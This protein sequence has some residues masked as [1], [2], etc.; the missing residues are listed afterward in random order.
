[1]TWCPARSQ[2]CLTT[3]PHLRRRP[4]PPPTPRSPPPRSPCTPSWRPAPPRPRSPAPRA[5]RSPGPHSGQTALAEPRKPPA[6]GPCA[7]GSG[8]RGGRPPASTCEAA[9]LQGRESPDPAGSAACDRARRCRCPVGLPGESGSRARRHLRRGRTVHRRAGRC[10]VPVLP[11][12]RRPAGLSRPP[13]SG[14]PA[15]QARPVRRPA[16]REE[17]HPEGRRPPVRLPPREGQGGGLQAL[18]PRAGSLAAAEERRSHRSAG[19]VGETSG[20]QDGPGPRG[21]SFTGSPRPPV[22]ASFPQRVAGSRGRPA[23][24]RATVPRGFGSETL[25][26]PKGVGFPGGALSG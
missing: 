21:A 18:P 6:A 2:A 23:G 8:S 16:R 5:P 24:S 25:P 15:P 7:T 3:P 17:P 1:M 22:S 20:L 4:C 11:R 10:G 14:L 13:G 19:P 12:D 26:V 9:R